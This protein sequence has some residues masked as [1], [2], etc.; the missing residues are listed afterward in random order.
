MHRLAVFDIDGTLTDTNTVDDE[1]FLRA[2]SEVLDIDVAL[3]DWS[4]APHVTDSD[5]LRWFAE[6]HCGR[7]LQPGESDAVLDRFLTLLSA[8]LATAPERFRPVSGAPLVF[9]ALRRANWRVALATGGWESS[10]QLKLRAIGLDPTTVPLA[11]ASDAMT[12]VAIL[13]LARDRAAPH[14]E[15]FSRIV[16]IGDG[17]WD[18]RAAADLRWPF[19]G[20]GTGDRVQRL[21]DAGAT[22]ILPDLM[23]VAALCTALDS[24]TVPP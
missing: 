5:L 11:S 23:D 20:I 15:T 24:A 18:V 21:R 4:G 7:S 1:C 14:G 2:V 8:Q 22:T 6:Q 9:D 16:S 13:E 19:V 3:L 12:R 10:A 17:V